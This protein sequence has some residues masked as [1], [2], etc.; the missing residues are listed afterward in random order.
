MFAYWVIQ[1]P[2]QPQT[3]EI[4]V[5]RS[6]AIL[7]PVKVVSIHTL[8]KPSAGFA[9]GLH[10]VDL[11]TWQD[12]N[13]ELLNQLDQLK[14]GSNSA[15]QLGMWTFSLRSFPSVNHTLRNSGET[16]KEIGPYAIF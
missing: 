11:F 16:I 10:L 14:G 3:S 4:V 13:K 1:D 5:P 9:E 15:F 2:D 7:F 8:L 12:F 6:L